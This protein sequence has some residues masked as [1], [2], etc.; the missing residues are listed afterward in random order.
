[1]KIKK[2]DYGYIK[3]QKMK[4]FWRTLGFFALPIAIF[5]VG[6]ILNKGDRL[7]IY[8]II[9]VVGCIPGCISAV[10]MITMW[11]RKPMSEELYKE[12]KEICGIQTMAYELYVTTQEASLFFDAVLFSGDSVTAYCDRTL[13]QDDINLLQAHIRK[14]LK[15]EKY[16]ANFR[17]LDQSSKK[18][19]MD[20]IRSGRGS[21]KLRD[22]S[23]EEGMKETL[24]LLAL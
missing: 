16:D 3:S 9:A 8:S 15:L 4:R 6:Y 20:R 18:Q 24:L 13:K 1:M 12:I 14:S 17:I 2:G 5:I 11:L 19:F 22:H 10:T 21:Y 23:R 7:N